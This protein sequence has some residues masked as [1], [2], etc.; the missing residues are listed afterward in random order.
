MSIIGDEGEFGNAFKDDPESKRSAFNESENTPVVATDDH[1][2]R[3]CL[4][5]VAR[6]TGMQL[7]ASKQLPNSSA[8]Y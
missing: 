1:R 5:G 4:T 7:S 3:P 8:R 2:Q 6:L